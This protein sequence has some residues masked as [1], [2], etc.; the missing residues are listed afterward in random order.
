M[1]AG[2]LVRV[3]GFLLLAWASDF[4]LFLLGAVVTGIGGALF[5]PAMQ[6][7]V[8]SAAEL[9]IALKGTKQEGATHCPA[10]RKNH[11]STLFT[12]LVVCGEVGAV[13][14]PLLASLLLKTGFDTALLVGAGVF[15][16]MAA[17]FL[18]FLPKPHRGAPP[19]TAGGKTSSSPA[20]GLW[21]CLKE[22]QFVRFTAFYSVNLL[23][24]NQLYF[25]LPV[26]LER[27]GGAG[28]ASALAVVFAY[29]SILTI[30]LQ[31][32]IARLMRKAGPEIALPVGFA[33][34]S[35]GFASIAFLAVIPPPSGLSM[36]P[37]LLLVT[38]LASGTC[39]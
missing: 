13:V 30:I 22:K 16:V 1:I 2:C 32:P 19:K 15:A 21:S 27:S 7:L 4:P 6:S 23:A 24:T 31:W 36:L 10:V 25:G 3:V 17:V 38:G 26:E 39:A 12:W 18:C 35:L 11:R 8:A 34:Q 5:A 9:P 29:A 14:G 28:G 20:P 33:L 37:A